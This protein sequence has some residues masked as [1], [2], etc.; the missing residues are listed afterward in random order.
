MVK[1]ALGLP[2]NPV[3]MQNGALI[4]LRSVGLVEVST[5]RASRLCRKSGSS[6]RMLNEPKLTELNKKREILHLIL[7]EE[8]SVRFFFIL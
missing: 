7:R 2:S 6:S 8:T 5:V 4:L 3:G 1:V